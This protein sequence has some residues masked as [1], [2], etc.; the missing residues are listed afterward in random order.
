MNPVGQEKDKFRH[1]YENGMSICIQ[2]SARLLGSLDQDPSIPILLS[3]LRECMEKMNG[4]YC[5]RYLHGPETDQT[6]DTEIASRNNRLASPGGA[7]FRNEEIESLK[8]SFETMAQLSTERANEVSLLRRQVGELKDQLRFAHLN[9]ARLETAHQADISRL[10]SA[11]IKKLEGELRRLQ[12]TPPSMVRES[13]LLSVSA[14]MSTVDGAVRH[15]HGEIAVL[16]RTNADLVAGMRQLDAD[17][18]RL[19]GQLQVSISPP[20]AGRYP[21]R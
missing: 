18:E 3:D 15:L 12:S 11:E 13:E 6:V 7:S 21:I 8:E 2:I 10:E 5:L 19:Q 14:E 20:A 1:N 4:E 16:Q 9:I 17:V